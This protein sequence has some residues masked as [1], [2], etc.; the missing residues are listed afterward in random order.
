MG[1]TA[2]LGFLHVRH[3]PFFAIATIA[4]L[5][6]QIAYL[7]DR[8][9]DTLHPYRA[10]RLSLSWLALCHRRICRHSASSRDFCRFQMVH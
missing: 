4:F 10:V 6:S 2:F 5:P 7:L 3:I 8:V 1:V 9:I